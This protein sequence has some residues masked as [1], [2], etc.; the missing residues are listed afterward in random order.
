[1]KARRSSHCCLCGGLVLTGT[2]IGLISFGFGR[3]GW[4]HVTCIVRPYTD[5]MQTPGSR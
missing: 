4:A 2:R 3:G 1:M 5:P